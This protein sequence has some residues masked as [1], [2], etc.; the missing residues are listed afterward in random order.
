MCTGLEL[1]ALAPSALQIG[2]A[3]L[4][5][6]GAIYNANTQNRAI[7]AQSRANRDAMEMDRAARAAE[8]ERQLAMEADQIRSVQEAMQQA[9]P[10]SIADRVAQ[11]TQGETD[12][13]R[14]ADETAIL[15]LPGQAASGKVGEKMGS[16]VGSALEQTRNMLRAQSV[17]S[18]QGGEFSGVSQALQRMSQDIGNVGAN[19]SRSAGVAQL[20]GRNP[21]AQVTPSQSILGDALIAAGKGV[22]QFAGGRQASM[23]QGIYRIPNSSP[24][25]QGAY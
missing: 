18:A 3:V 8:S 12:F 5:A 9:N 4:P 2:S 6:V 10:A 16:I 13:T 23:D 22:G 14:A 11:Q 21:P 19:R 24:W 15:A 20:E 1:A 7:E 17:L 25:W